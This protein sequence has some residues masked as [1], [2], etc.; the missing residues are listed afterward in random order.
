MRLGW[1]HGDQELFSIEQMIQLF[2]L[3]GV[4]ESAASFDPAKFLWVNEQ[5]LK[6]APKESIASSLRPFL[7]ARDYDLTAGPPLEE[8]VEVQRDRARA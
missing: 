1:S 5:W 3:D 2:S 8:I 7:E 6:Q 4:N